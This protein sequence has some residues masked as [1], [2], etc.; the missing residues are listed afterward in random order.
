[1]TMTGT[2]L[3]ESEELEQQGDFVL[4]FGGLRGWREAL[5]NIAVP[6]NEKFGEIPF[7]HTA[8]K[9]TRVLIFQENIEWMSIRPIHIYFGKHWKCHPII[10][11]AKIHDLFFGSWFLRTKLVAGKA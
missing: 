7:N 9:E 1:M 10:D 2:Y 3:S 11:T 4:D 6:I 8:A 5:H